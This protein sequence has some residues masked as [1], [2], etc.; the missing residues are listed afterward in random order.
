M[1]I[2]ELREHVVQTMIVR[3]NHVGMTLKL[4]WQIVLFMHLRT[5]G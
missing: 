2:T 1:L 5:A 4:F 3:R